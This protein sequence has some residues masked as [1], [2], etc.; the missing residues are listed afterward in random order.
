MKKV[1]SSSTIVANMEATHPEVKTSPRAW[2]HYRTSVGRQSHI[3]AGDRVGRFLSRAHLPASL[4][5]ETNSEAKSELKA[6]KQKK[7][8][9]KK[10]R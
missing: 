4:K 10:R 7:R 9:V 3:K 6:A 8:R 5:S 2:S 1:T